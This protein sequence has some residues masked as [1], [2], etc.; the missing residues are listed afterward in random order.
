MK[1]RG[2]RFWTCFLALFFMIIGMYTQIA[3]AA[4]GSIK[5]TGTIAG[6]KYS[7]YRILDLTLTGAGTT[8]K[9]SYSL[10]PKWKSFFT[11][12]AGTGYLLDT[13]P[14]G[15][16]NEVVV[17]G[18]VKYLNITANNVAEFSKVAMGE[19]HKT[20]ITKA[21][22]EEATGTVV[23]FTGLDLGYYLMHPEG[24]TDLKTGQNSIVSLTSTVPN[25]EVAVKA[26]YP[27]IKKEADKKSADFGE[28]I[29]FTLKSKVPDITG[30]NQ[31]KFVVSDTLSKGLSFV[32][33]GGGVPGVTVKFAESVQTVSSG[34]TGNIHYT[35]ETQAGTGETILTISFDMTKFQANKGKEIT[36][37]Y[38]AKLN[39]DAVIGNGGN[40]NKVE[41]EYS[42]DPKDH[43]KTEKTPPEKVKVYSGKIKVIKYEK[44]NLAN[45]LS[46]AKF[47]LY[48]ED[49]GVKKYYKLTAS[50]N[51]KVV[52]WVTDKNDADALETDTDGV[53]E[54]KGLRAGTYKLQETVA[55]A[56]YN[57][58]LNDTQVILNDVAATLV[59]E[60]ESQIENSNGVE[61]PK[62][63]GTGTKLFFLLGG[64]LILYAGCSLL[65]GNA[66]KKE[67]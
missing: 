59:M 60:A 38:K 52:T 9:V 40:P 39:K 10:D 31:Y 66:A 65:K 20:G 18:A 27:T 58:L 11:T 42:N 3:F 41:L 34:T 63:G 30:F 53:I 45:K 47:V 61:L 32:E 17:D 57:L 26:E 22:T 67:N 37:I 43:T 64:A 48:K 36:I 14:S 46:G 6:K 55:P 1:N 33:P 25:G 4:T 19:I 15:Q 7:L 51:E 21:M 23:N 35:T 12:G 2:K 28:E 62:T 29:T 44:G 54:F 56:G 13:D 5:V 24:A 8:A 49:A 50:G 16:L